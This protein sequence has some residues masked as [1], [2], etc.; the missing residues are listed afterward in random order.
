MCY[1]Y[2]CHAGSNRSFTAYVFKRLDP[3]GTP[4]EGSED[5]LLSNLLTAPRLLQASLPRLLRRRNAKPSYAEVADEP[6]PVVN[7]KARPRGRVALADTM[8]HL[9]SSSQK[10]GPKDANGTTEAAAECVSQIN[11]RPA[12]QASGGQDPPKIT[13]ATLCTGKQERPECTHI[14]STG[15]VE[16]DAAQQRTANRHRRHVEQRKGCGRHKKIHSAEDG[17]CDTTRRPCAE[18]SNKSQLEAHGDD[19]VPYGAFQKWLFAG[20]S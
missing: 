1:L 2:H 18:R 15:P 3:P 16:Q 7:S 6:V 20:K 5:A 14:P 4:Y 12:I 13:T 17:I 10:A 9:C 8:P 11:S 19:D